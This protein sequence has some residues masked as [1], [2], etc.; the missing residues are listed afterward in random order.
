M[1]GDIAVLLVEVAA[2]QGGSPTAL[3]QAALRPLV[4]S[5]RDMLADLWLFR[6]VDG[7]FNGRVAIAITRWKE[8]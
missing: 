3:A 8:R 2:R 4:G 1:P 5:D 6:P 7:A